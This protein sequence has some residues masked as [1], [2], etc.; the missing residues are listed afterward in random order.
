M[1]AHDLFGE[2]LDEEIGL[3]INGEFIG[4]WT[5]QVPR[6]PRGMA[7]YVYGYSDDIEPYSVVFDNV[8]AWVPV[9]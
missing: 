5:L 3:I 8:R 7:L 4:R 1:P 6:E 9:Q 2:C